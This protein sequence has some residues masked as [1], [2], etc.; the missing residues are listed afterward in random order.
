MTDLATQKTIPAGIYLMDMNSFINDA[1]IRNSTFL[2]VI[3]CHF[4]KEE[5]EKEEDKNK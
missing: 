1:D 3:K 5:K 2:K 4:T